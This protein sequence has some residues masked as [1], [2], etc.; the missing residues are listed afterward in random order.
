MERFLKKIFVENFQRKL[1]AIL[2]A[3]CIWFFVHSSITA[4]RTFTHVPIRVVN[5]VAD[6]TV[7]GLMPNGI[8]DRKLTLTLTGNRDVIEKLEPGD[9][10]V[11]IDA[12]GKPDEWIVQ[13]AKKNLVSLNPDIDLIH[14]VSSLSQNEFVLRLSKQ[15]T[16]KVPIY[17]THPKGEPPEGYQFLDIWPQKLSQIVSGPEEDVKALQAKGI[18][19]T[20][21]LNDITLEELNSLAAHE[22]VQGDEVSFNVPDS[23]KKVQIPF[24]HAMKQEINGPEAKN[25]HI[26][27]LRKDL[28]ALDCDVP[29]RVFYPRAT[30]STINPVTSP[31]V[32]TN[33]IV[34]KD[35]LYA[36]TIPL[37]VND[38]SR[39]F[40]DIVR[41]HIEV[42]I[43][44]ARKEPHE[45]L[46]VSVEFV[47]PQA[48]EEEY[49]QLLLSSSKDM[50]GSQQSQR[51]QA[52]R[53]RF[54]EYMQRFSL[55]SEKGKPFQL[56]AF[57]EPSGIVVKGFE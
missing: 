19:L 16:D 18:E 9:F 42:E 26:D 22:T 51:E 48:L 7:R 17:I 55:L 1:I 14:S 43:I 32:P 46:Q 4:T 12:A 36:L 2:S 3:V 23:W 56:K 40:L 30:A 53:I 27:F 45:P 52:L 24:L 49:V 10:E 34:E 31:L 5:L 8:L 38:V 25:L 41:N 28:I 21:D 13:V 57:F 33:G 29:V 47:D 11:V 6:K 37:Y 54:R 39:L 20:F 15:L 50:I 35:Q 44:A